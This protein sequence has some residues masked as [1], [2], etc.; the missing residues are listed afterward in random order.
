M[1]TSI[2]IHIKTLHVLLAV[3]SAVGFVLRA[4]CGLLGRRSILRRRWVRVAPH[5]VDT[6]LLGAG[7]ALAMSYSLSPLQQ[8]WFA[9]KLLL[10]VLYIGSGGVTI[11]RAREGGSLLPW[12]LAALLCLAGVFASALARRPLGLF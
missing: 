8:P 9:T 2:L 11:R 5:V 10:I 1:T 3:L 4:G 7:V 12:L 6:A